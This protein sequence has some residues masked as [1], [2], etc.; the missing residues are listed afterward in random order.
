MLRVYRNFI[1]ALILLGFVCISYADD[2]APA[3]ARRVIFPK[4]GTFYLSLSAP[5]PAGFGIGITHFISEYF[6][7][8]AEFGKAD[9]I[10]AAT[11]LKFRPAAGAVSPMIG[12]MVARGAEPAAAGGGGAAST[13]ASAATGG[14]GA[15]TTGP[16]PSPAPSIR[17]FA[18]VA[19]GIDWKW[20]MGM[21]LHIGVNWIFTPVGGA[22]QM[23]PVLQIGIP[24]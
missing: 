20:E 17:G 24:Y 7:L 8:V 12:L 19:T 22:T 9:V 6:A 4:R 10:V 1:A 18:Y 21:F 2:A 5:Y 11:G 3:P 16:T 13:S 23:K 15:T 14:I